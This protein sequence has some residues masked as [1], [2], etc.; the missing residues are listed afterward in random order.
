MKRRHG[1]TLVEL[2]V[3][4]AILAL[5]AG[6]ASVAWQ[7]AEASSQAAR[8][9]SQMR[10]LG[11]AIHLWGA[12]RGGEFPRSSHSAFAHRSRG[13]PREI[14]PYLGEADGLIT[15][16]LAARYFR[17]PADP[18]TRGTSYG[19]NVFLEL[20]PATDD[21]EG[22]PLQWRRAA[23]LPA[24]SR[25]VLLA[26]IKTESSADHVMAHFWS[27]R[28]DGSE[29]AADRHD[30]KSH[31]VFADGHA[32]RLAV[33]ETYDPARAIDCWHPGR[34]GTGMNRR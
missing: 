34:A 33:E 11:A 1:F 27:G 23:A 18:R 3:V 19:L 20:D 7:R 17:C 2:L 15:P 25:T 22:A 5:L 31:F 28:A 24:P 21:Y 9:L 16:R 32:A 6:V 10:Q 26:E 13:W 30:G 29:V 8:C 14:L 12:D 4:L